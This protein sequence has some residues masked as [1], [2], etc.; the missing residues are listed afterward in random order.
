MI[1]MVRPRMTDANTPASAP[2]VGFRP[3]GTARNQ[4]RFKR[5]LISAIRRGIV[6]VAITLFALTFLAA[7]G[8]PI[9]P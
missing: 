6:F 1:L 7:R 3:F 4:R 8:S 5:A 2:T 9:V